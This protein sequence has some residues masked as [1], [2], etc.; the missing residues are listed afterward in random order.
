MEDRTQAR[1][2]AVAQAL[3]EAQGRCPASDEGRTTSDAGSAR[4]PCC[5]DCA[6]ALPLLDGSRQLLACTNDP[7]RPKRLRVT[8]PSD[9]CPHFRRRRRWG[10]KTV[11]PEPTEE[12]IRYIPL[13]QGKYAV[14]EAADYERAAMF[15]WHASNSGAR[16]YACSNIGGRNVSLHRFLMNPPAGMVVDHIDHDGLNDRRS[17]L[18]ICT[19]RQNLYNSRPKGRSSRFKGVCWDKAR[20]RWVVY[21]RYGGRNRFIGQFA[22]E[23]EAAKAYDRAAASLFGEYAYLN[24]PKEAMHAS[25]SLGR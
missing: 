21:I 3:A 6:H 17:N 11:P 10:G 19:Q 5:A 4:S 15:S 7:G 18:R 16:T 24:F 13:T 2:A 25:A 14:I 9:G 8:D 1:R 20:Q 23:I 12:G 22:D